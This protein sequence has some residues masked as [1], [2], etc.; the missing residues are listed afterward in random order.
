MAPSIHHPRGHGDRGIYHP[1]RPWRQG[2]SIIPCLF[3]IGA[4]AHAKD[5]TEIRCDRW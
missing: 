3:R 5:S 2:L 1:R 4:A